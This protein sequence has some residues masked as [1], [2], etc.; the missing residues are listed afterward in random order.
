M[1]RGAFEDV[2]LLTAPKF[3]FHVTA[4]TRNAHTVLRVMMGWADT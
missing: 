2:I 1:K 4:L 3:Y